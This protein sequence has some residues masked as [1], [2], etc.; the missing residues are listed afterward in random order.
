MY[1]YLLNVQNVIIVNC[2]AIYNIRRLE[3]LCCHLEMSEFLAVVGN[4]QH[5]ASLCAQ[6]NKLRS[7]DQRVRI[8]LQFSYM[9][10]WTVEFEC[11]LKHINRNMI[12]CFFVRRTALTV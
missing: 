6:Y 11:N 7:T 9:M 8:S 5:A 12:I 4:G 3:G 2:D 1:M 10:L